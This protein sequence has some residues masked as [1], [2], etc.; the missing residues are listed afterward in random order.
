MPELTV[1]M[2]AFRAGPF[3]EAAIKSVLEDR[4]IDLELVV[5]DDGSDDDTAR[6]AELSGDS[7]LR[8]LRNETRRGIGYCHNRV[9]KESS[10]AII[11]HVDA[12]DF[13]LPGA[14]RTLADAVLESPDVGQAFCDFF[15]VEADGGTMA[16]ARER[17]LLQLRAARRHERDV[18][19]ALL[20]HG[21]V[22]NH[23]RTYRREVFDVVGGFDET[24]SYAVDYEM[25][26][27]IAERYR[28]AYVPE[29]LYVKRA[30]PAATTGAMRARN[31]RF[32]WTRYRIGHRLLRTQ[33]GTLLGRGSPGFHALMALGLVH[34]AGA[35]KWAGRIYR[36][37]RGTTDTG[38]DDGSTE[39]R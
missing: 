13:I 10:S 18:P 8:V 37:L 28:F 15:P 1:S 27:R 16:D 20:V 29:P 32:W 11:A 22:V 9:I 24:L 3:I 17:W 35:P 6:V 23:L 26:L 2:P 5:V 14:L 36:S 19:R 21:M 12:D 38:L 31:L 25:A 39:S 34:V 7:R 4:D 30:H 33:G